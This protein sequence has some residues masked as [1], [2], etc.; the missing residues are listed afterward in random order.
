[1]KN[2][3]FFT[4]GGT[5]VHPRHVGNHSYAGSKM[6]HTT[7]AGDINANNGGNATHG[8]KRRHRALLTN[9]R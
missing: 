6:H 9:F 5:I 8:R 7:D 2:L 4:G 1:M 3:L